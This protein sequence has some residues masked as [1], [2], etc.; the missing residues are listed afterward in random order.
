MP[1]ARAYRPPQGHPVLLDPAFP[2][3][4]ELFQFIW[5]QRLFDARGLRTVD[6]ASVAVERPGRI[7]HGSG[8]DLVDARIRIA[9]QLWS[10]TVEVHVRSSEWYAHGHAADPA[11]GGV[12]LHVAY[13]HDADVRLHGGRVIPAVEL[14]D[15]IPH[16]QLERY[17]RLM[18]DKAWVPCASLLGEVD[19]ARIG[20]WLERL[21]VERLERKASEVLQLHASMQADAS[22]TFWV[23][24]ARAFGSRTNADPFGQLARSLPLKLLLKYR[25]DPARVKAL[26]HG[27]AGLW[28]TAAGAAPM[29]TLQAEYALLAGMHG[30]RPMAP[31]QWRA[32]G[33][34]PACTPVLRLAQLAAL[35]PRWEEVVR[36]LVHAGDPAD[37]LHLLTRPG[38]EPDAPSALGNTAAQHVLI[39]AVVPYLFAMGRY[40]GR[41]DLEERALRW[42]EQLPAEENGVLRQWRS[43]G[44]RADSAARGQALLE[45]KNNWCGQRRCLSCVIGTCILKGGGRK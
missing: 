19:P 42:M 13:V 29:R 23:L 24:L 17:Q 11:Y 9:G 41:P 28:P 21:L 25:D 37:A 44:I 5:E 39:N 27:Q 40:S 22:E 2:Y 10:G 20:L 14:L 26:V 12:V 36:A 34:R 7:Q 45:L 18:Q 33:V 4:E 15:R 16:A 35:L 31:G 8:P 30:L 43:L 6:G 32:G 38:V 3:R 1:H